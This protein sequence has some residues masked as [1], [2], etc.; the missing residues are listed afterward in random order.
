MLKKM[1]YKAIGPRP[2]PKAVSLAKPR[3]RLACAVLVW[4][5]ALAGLSLV[6]A[7]A[8]A[9]AGPVAPERN[10][11]ETVPSAENPYRHEEAIQKLTVQGIVRAEKTER[12]IVRIADIDGLAV[13]K[14]GDKIALRLDGLVHTFTV[15]RIQA[16]SVWFQAL[17]ARDAAPD[18]DRIRR[19]SYEVFVQ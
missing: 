7:L 13:L 11:F 8:A 6:S 9:D 5:M 1:L 18:D 3:R 16:K 12:I 2:R 19:Q 17:P 4:S 14:K 15:G 10:P